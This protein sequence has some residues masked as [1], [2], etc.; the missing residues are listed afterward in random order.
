MVNSIRTQ[1][2]RALGAGAVAALLSIAS[3]SA[4]AQPTVV[5]PD[6]A[7]EPR[8]TWTIVTPDA[9]L[10]WYAVLSDL[11][12]PGPGAFAYVARSSTPADREFAAA[13]AASRES[14]IL[15]FVPLYHPS[16]DRAALVAALRAAASASGAPPPRAALLVGALTQVISADRRARELPRLATAL[17]RAHPVVPSDAAVRAWQ[18][19]LDSAYLPALASWL[20]AERLDA[21]RLIVAPGLGAEG[22]LFA[23][24]AARDDN[25][26]AVGRFADDASSEAPLLAFVRE[27]CFPAVTRA[28]RDAGLDER[29]GALARRASI[30]AVRCGAALLDARL[31]SRAREYRAFW[32]RRTT[33]V[34]PAPEGA[35]EGTD[36][37]LRAAFDRAFPVDPALTDRLERAIRTSQRSI[38]R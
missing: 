5:R 35:R 6:A 36:P 34:P 4:T 28:A 31:P 1:V 19:A 29:N 23:A 13:L 17:E 18:E 33:D 32:L 25:L 10:A 15:H 37:S 8:V 38:S 7:G 12:L 30:A 21:G 14:E 20:E 3:L 11:A 16:A 9:A 27:A 24:T 22:R 26:V 2:T